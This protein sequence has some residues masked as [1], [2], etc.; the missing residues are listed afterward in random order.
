MN[1]I[2]ITPKLIRILKAYTRLFKKIEGK[3]Y[4]SI[5]KLEKQMRKETDIKDIEFVFCDGE[6][7]G[8]GNTD[9]TM[10][11]IFRYKLEK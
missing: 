8:I 10:E 7:S 9:R 5:D 3:Y 2:K 6:F 11:L 4:S 1:K